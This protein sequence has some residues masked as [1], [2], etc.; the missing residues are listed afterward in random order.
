MDVDD[1]FLLLGVRPDASPRAI[2]E[3]FR[4][5]AFASHPDRNPND[6]EAEERFKRLATA[7]RA[8]LWR[9]GR[10]RRAPPDRWSTRAPLRYACPRCGDTY[11]YGPT[12]PRCDEPLTDRFTTVSVPPFPDDPEVDAM[13]E[14]LE[15]APEAPIDEVDPAPLLP[16]L[17]GCSAM[18]GAAALDVGLM[19]LGILC[20]LFGFLL[21]ARAIYEE[22]GPEPAWLRARAS[23][24]DLSEIRGSCRGATG[25]A[26]G[27]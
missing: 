16:S 17:A 23:A 8:A 19:P 21:A 9:R 18:I 24:T 22:L 5:L 15:R 7:Y 25:P 13:I 6:P 3:A 12:C 11:S 26:S 2:H 4:R 14:R 1:P 27:S 10:A 20:I